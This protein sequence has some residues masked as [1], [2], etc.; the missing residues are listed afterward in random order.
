MAMDRK[1]FSLDGL[2]KKTTVFSFDEMNVY[3]GEGDAKRTVP[4]ADVV[5]LSRTNNSLN[6]R[7]FWR[8][9]YRINDA[10]EVAQF[11][12]N[13]TLWNRNFPQF[14]ARLSEAN[15]AAVMRRLRWWDV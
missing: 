13:T 15:P 4:F 6:N 5:S 9:E 1:K 11:R 12:T 8:L 14:H 3:I 10:N 7:Y 2:I